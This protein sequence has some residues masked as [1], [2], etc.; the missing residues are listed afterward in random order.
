M[1]RLPTPGSDSGSWGNILNDFLAVEHNPN[2]SLK[3]GADIDAAQA[4]ASRQIVAGTGL[5]GGGD[6]GSDVTLNVSYGTTAG[7]AAQGNDSRFA[8]SS[9]GTVGASLSATDSSV[10]NSRSPN[11][12]ASGDLSGSYPSPTVAKINGVTIS[13]APSSGNQVL[14]TTSTT[15]AQWSAS[16]GIPAQVL[17]ATADCVIDRDAYCGPGSH[18]VASTSGLYTQAMV[19]LTAVFIQGESGGT[20]DVVTTVQSVADSN[21]LVLTAAIPGGTGD[22]QTLIIGTDIS[23]AIS[24][25][26]ASAG[27]TNQQLFIPAG[28]YLK[29]STITV[30][31]NI[32]VTGAG[33]EE[34]LIVHAS[35]TT[36][37][38]TGVDTTGIIFEDWSVIGPGQG[39]GTGNG[40]NLTLSTH[41]ATFYPTLRR[42]SA[43]RFGVDGIAI[44]T[45]IVGHFDQ[46]VPML[47]GQHGFN[48]AGAGEADGTSCQFTA[49]FPAGNWGAGYRLKQMAYSSLD[50][51]AADAN[52]VAYLY[53][54]CIGI[55]ESGCGSEETY[56]FNLLGRTSFTPNGL[57]RYISNSKVVMNSPFMIQN[58]GTSCW[59]ANGSKVVIND[60]YEG[61]AGN[62]D[63]PNSNP[64]AS[65][66]VDSG[67]TV[68]VN[69]YQ[70]VTAMSLAGGTT[71]LMPDALSSLP[72]G[73]IDNLTS[74]QNTLPRFICASAV[75]MGA[76]QSLRL[77]YFTATASGTFTQL[78][79]ATA[80]PAAGA[81]PSLCKMGLYSID[82]AGAGTLIASTASDTTL[83]SATNT[84]YTR[85][86]QAS[87]TVT[88]GSRYALAVLVVTGAAIP[89]IIGASMA[90]SAAANSIM[91]EAPRAAGS[92]GS[93]A[94]LP[95][96]FADA[97]LTGVA[98]VFYGELVP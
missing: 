33:R 95:P 5:T 7:T 73:G 62:P 63:D 78:R 68:V 31:S 59:V 47:N 42:F 66:K 85:A 65:L 13:N 53:D 69:N 20:S 50:G 4:V 55:T 84:V 87:Y 79:T 8:G 15:A 48:F 16:S 97:S 12:S 38:F 58:V 82:G 49:C 14:V 17:D 60:Y 22:P 67:C 39:L 88:A 11:G 27:S 75:S 57:S 9:A 86:T 74:S 43:S 52:G 45:P 61:S 28:S 46:V 10:T 23:A 94:D 81:T 40:L 44:S 92:L 21:H 19:G 26:F 18:N 41:P 3:R 32:V 6:L 89:S 71:T 77:S 1:A 93:Q 80:T 30:P 24:A 36:D 35:S 2:G 70:N 34:T 29:T 64:Q 83:W 54:T 91:A 37:A 90:G 98:S 51:C 76:S 72:S 96:S 56:N 25:A